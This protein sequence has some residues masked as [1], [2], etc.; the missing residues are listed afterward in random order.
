MP[1]Q[2]MG[3][4]TPMQPIR[5]GQPGMMPINMQPRP[6]MNQPPRPGGPP[7]PGMRPQ[8]I[9]GQFQQYR[10]GGMMPPQSIPPNQQNIYPP[11]PNPH[12]VPPHFQHQGMMPPPPREIQQT[13]V[14]DAAKADVV[15]RQDELLT[16][17]SIQVKPSKKKIVRIYECPGISM[18]ELRSRHEKYQQAT[19]V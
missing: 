18:E 4:F 15:Q 3:S 14:S 12:L 16:Q 6:P 17:A 13:P 8:Q 11:P 2:P 10:P 9:P 5:P 1:M 19:H 7:V